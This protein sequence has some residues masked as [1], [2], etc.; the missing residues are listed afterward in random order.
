[1]LV[2]LLERIHRDTLL[3]ILVGN[4]SGIAVIQVC[5]IG[6]GFLV[7]ILFARWME[8]THYGIFALAIS[9]MIIGVALAKFGFDT[10]SLRFLSAYE[11]V[12]NWKDFRG[13]L[14]FSH[15]LV[16]FISLV[17]TILAWTIIFFLRK[18]LSPEIFLALCVTFVGIPIFSQF[19]LIQ[20]DLRALRHTVLALL[21]DPLLRTILLIGMTF[22]VFR[23][24]GHLTSSQALG[25]NVL[26]LTMLLFVFG[27]I[28][29]RR[30][31]PSEGWRGACTYHSGE[32]LHMAF[33]SML[34]ANM[35]IILN[36]TDIVMVG[37]LLGPKQTGFYASASKISILT[38]FFLAAL[39]FIMAPMIARFYARQEL[40]SLQRMTILVCR[41]LSSVAV[42]LVLFI[43]LTGKW[44]LLLFGREF[45]IAYPSLMILVAGRFVN[46]L[47][48]PAGFLL[49]MTGQ[50]DILTLIVGISVLMN[51]LLNGIFIPFWGIN[52]AAL[53]T[54]CS[55]ITWKLLA[56]IFVKRRIGIRVTLF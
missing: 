47:T 11:G 55:I 32:W 10:A 6:I 15:T 18:R 51:I 45:V 25:L 12:E 8:P 53:A 9:W 43:M 7:N 16:F 35:Y 3:S 50:Q 48:G 42:P 40:K 23:F 4:I 56:V 37:A 26:A 5:G 49:S 14:R 33:A 27:I 24:T 34:I 54:T 44:I 36:Q 21:S 31:I 2:R 29:H 13:F 41:I 20:A 52:G 28:L 38:N 17:V 19:Q 46:V 30:V 39:D 1:M 22:V